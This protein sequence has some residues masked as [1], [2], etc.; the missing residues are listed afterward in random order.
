MKLSDPDPLEYIRASRR[1]RSSRGYFT[2]PPRT[3]PYEPHMNPSQFNYHYP[4]YQPYGPRSYPYTAP[5]WNHVPQPTA[6]PT[7]QDGLALSAEAAKAQEPVK[8][9][10]QKPHV[11]VIPRADTADSEFGSMTP[12]LDVSPCLKMSIVRQ[13]EEAVWNCDE[14]ATRNSIPGKAIMASLIG[15]KS[16]RNT[17]GLDLAH[18]LIQGQDM[19]FVYVRGNGMFTIRNFPQ[20]LISCRPWGDLVHQRAT[21]VSPILSLWISPT[22]LP[23]QRGRYQGHET[24]LRSY[25]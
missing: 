22:I 2:P 14:F 4:N 16:A 7:A 3:A 18:T 15:D 13:G 11:V 10:F 20:L 1:R 21:S 12:K 5:T 6:Q 9:K 25:R 19:K 17:H 23:Y 24:R 8:P